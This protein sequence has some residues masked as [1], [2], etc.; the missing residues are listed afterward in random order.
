[1]EA[2]REMQPLTVTRVVTTVAFLIGYGCF[3]CFFFYVSTI[4]DTIFNPPPPGEIFPDSWMAE[5]SSLDFHRFILKSSK[6]I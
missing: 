5:I 3:F 2:L 1:M 6:R 4:R